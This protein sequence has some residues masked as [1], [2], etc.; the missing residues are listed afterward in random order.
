MG[1]KRGDRKDGRWIRDID[2]F[3]FIMPY[4]MP[5]RC[6][7]EV[8]I[9]ELIDVTEMV[10]YIEAH[11]SVNK[12]FRLT[13]FHV[14]TAAVGKIIY[15][16]PYLNRFVAGRRLYQRNKITLAFVVKR[17]FNDEAEESL[18]V[19]EI[20][21]DT[22][23]EQIS[24]RIAGDAQTIRKEGGNDINDLLDKLSKLPRWL[25]RLA[26]C[27]FR[28][29]DFHGWMPESICRGDSNYA[30]VLLSNLGS[31][32]CNAVYHHLNN[33]GTNSI[34]I[35]IG[36]IH[37]ELMADD[38]GNTSVRDVV[39]IGA[40]ADERIADGFYFAR[41][42]RMLEEILRDPQQLENKMKSE[43]RQRTV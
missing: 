38:D 37:K 17:R 39:A 28:F 2:G 20:K 16:R 7:S 10:K 42:I 26:M 30:S 11:N 4:L 24:R 43:I 27:V 19:T 12:E 34:V 21:E 22:T 1:K 23:L 40:T 35:T 3:H 32:K 36:R 5:N 25:M 15:H 6:D 31:I 33:Y 9:E 41:S 29:L 8:Y 13:P 18:L 14:I